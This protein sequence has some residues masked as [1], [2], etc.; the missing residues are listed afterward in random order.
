ML[1]WILTGAVALAVAAGLAWSVVAGRRATGPAEAFDIRVY[2][3]QLGEIDADAARGKIDAVEAER[4]RVEISRRLLA[5][6]TKARGETVAA[7]QPQAMSRAM[8]GVLAL[9]LL[10][11]G[12]ALYSQLG[13]PGYRDM[14]LQLRL[15][16]AQEALK[17]RASQA[18]A[19][20]AM[21]QGQQAEAPE[22]YRTLV[23]KLRTAVAERPD[24]L[25][26][27]ILLARSEGALGNYAASY[28]ALQN[29]V[30]I[31]G[32]KATAQDYADLADMLVLAA[33]GYVSPE[34][35]AALER[36]LQLDKS[37][38]VARFYGGLMMAQTGRP[39]IGFRMWDALLDDSQPDDPWVEPLR[40]Q[41]EEMAIRAGQNRYQLPPLQ[42]MAGPS[43]ADVAAA[44]EMSEGDRQEMVRGMVS[45]L[46]DRLATEGGT[47]EEWARLVTALGVLGDT[48]Q[49]GKVWTEAKQ[50]FAGRNAALDTIRAAAD[51]AGVTQ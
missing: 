44:G 4:L 31:K 28:E 18:E 30:R 15:E 29:V 8:A 26:G 40:A 10:G 9:V 24:D 34:A 39:D 49:A 37:N 20:A 14:P 27:Q 48:E 47:P 23:E 33:G 41:I 42:E 2:R 11:G 32:D 7:A 38:G 13:A 5:A 21:P 1:F 35:Q 3:D 16:M 19:E 50:V 6:D 36:A 17:D 51:R 45:R 43:A 25:Q 46:S 12:Y 22:D